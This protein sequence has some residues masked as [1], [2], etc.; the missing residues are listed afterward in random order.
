MTL[1]GTKW[2]IAFSIGKST[3]YWPIAGPAG[4]SGKDKFQQWRSELAMRS[5]FVQVPMSSNAVAQA[6]LTL[7][8]FPPARGYNLAQ[9]DG[10][11]RLIRACSLLLLNLLGLHMS[12]DSPMPYCVSLFRLFILCELFIFGY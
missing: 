3:T 2:S 7:N 8:M 4:R 12:L 5:C 11:L 1:E 10:T 6:Q 9:G